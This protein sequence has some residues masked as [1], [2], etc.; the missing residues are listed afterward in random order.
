MFG[1][2]KKKNGIEK[3]YY[4]NG[5]LK[6]EVNYDNGKKHGPTKIYH[7]NGKIALEGEFNAG[8]RYGIM[9]SYHENGGKS[10]QLEYNIL[11]LETGE[12]FEWYEG[13]QLKGHQSSYSRGEANGVFTHFYPNGQMSIRGKASRGKID[14]EL[15]EWDE[16][17]NLIKT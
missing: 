15:E 4:H 5:D 2:G 8:K 1:F 6:S 13:G 16:N 14:G 9:T 10:A 3:E 11:G 7:E 12:S 17:G